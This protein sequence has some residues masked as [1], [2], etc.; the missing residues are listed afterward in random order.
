[1]QSYSDSPHPGVLLLHYRASVADYRYKVVRC[2]PGGKDCADQ[3]RAGSRNLVTT[4]T[5]GD[6]A[7]AAEALL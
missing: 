7:P 3:A 5:I 6:I 2:E 1:M 4:L